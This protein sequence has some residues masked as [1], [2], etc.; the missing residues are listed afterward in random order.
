M[1]KDETSGHARLGASMI[2]RHVH[3]FQPHNG[4]HH[5]KKV[6]LTHSTTSETSAEELV[7]NNDAAGLY[8][9]LKRKGANAC[10]SIYSD[11]NL[12]DIALFASGNYVS[13]LF[14]S[15][16]FN[17]RPSIEILSIL[18]LFGIPFGDNESAALI[19]FNTRTFGYNPKKTLLDFI[20]ANFEENKA[21]MSASLDEDQPLLKILR[22]G[23]DGC[24]VKDN[25]WELQART[26]LLAKDENNIE[27]NQI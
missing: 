23:D 19:A 7:K 15:C 11:G 1:K 8:S 3:V 4:R 16:G 20:Q 22:H 27:T 18:A 26:I 2:V 13:S 21:L 5:Q 14:R 17:P 25:A 9:F 24:F 6:N 10:R 12:W